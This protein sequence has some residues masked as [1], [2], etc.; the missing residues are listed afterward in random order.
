MYPYIN[1]KYDCFVVEKIIS[2]VSD[3][4]I[5]FVHIVSIKLLVPF[6]SRVLL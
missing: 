4:S 2:H 1:Y 3:I 5:H 6:S